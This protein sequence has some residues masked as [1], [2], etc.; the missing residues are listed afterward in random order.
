MAVPGGEGRSTHRAGILALLVTLSVTHARAQST[1]EQV[2]PILEP[3][4]QQP[5]IVE[6]QL[7][8]YL[9]SHVIPLNNPDTAERWKKESSQI[10][11]HLIDDVLFH[12]WPKEYVTSPPHF[13]DR[14]PIP[15][16]K[17]YHLRRLQYEIVPGFWS[18]ALLYEPEDLHGKVPAILNVNGHFKEGKASE[19]KQKRSINYALRGMLV[20]DLEWLNMGELQNEQN[21]HGFGGHLELAGANAGGL[22]YLAMRRG[23]DYL[24]G[25]PS[26]DTSRI[27]MTGLSGGGWQT[28]TLGSLD[29]R[30]AVAIPV[31]GYDALASDAAHPLWVGVD[32]EWNPSDFR[33]AYDYTTLTALRAPRPT[34][35]VYNAEDDCCFRAP[36]VKPYV[37]DA[38]KPFYRLFAKEEAFEWHENLDPS[39]HN[40]QLDNRQQSYRFFTKYFHLPVTEREIPVDAEIKTSEELA[41]GL[42]KDN[43]TVL[44]LAREFAGKI[45]RQ[46]I[47]AES[48]RRSEWCEKTRAK[49]QQVVRYKPVT[50]RHPWAEANTKGKGIETLSYRFEFGN[51]L[52]ATGIWLKAIA[53]PQNAPITLIL[54]DEGKR[55][56]AAE[57]SDRV[58]R[59]EQVLALDLLFTGD[60]APPDDRPQHGTPVYTQFLAA[61][62]ER[63]LGM[64]AAQLIA[65]ARWASGRAGNPKLRLETTGMRSQV[66][67][68]VATALEPTLF[69]EL[70]A[71]KGMQSL[72]FLLEKPVAY[73]AAPDL[74]CLDLYREFDLSTLALLAHPTTII[75]D[76]A[77][78]R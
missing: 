19:F 68:L 46:P 57:V 2:S 17:G 51:G 12:G 18:T 21:D 14:G 54:N 56:E 11:K 77:R 53:P 76:S 70:V 50:L 63:P 31:A 78:A 1:P 75:Q 9:M 23:L 4:I 73:E 55:A 5:V 66:V 43:L 71:H 62:G 24:C 65:L 60:S 36:I 3:P 49:L 22:F 61:L 28:I 64:E 29:E 48:G 41:V 8:E 26:V 42:P 45:Q 33:Q 15:T 32:I 58:N 67:G 40:Y 10:R 59:G 34:L 52:S 38:I 7:K 69:H 39:T 35:L 74:F 44:G 13:E 16:G 6:Y 47:P 27:G 30:V 20:L 25:H 72:G 37:F